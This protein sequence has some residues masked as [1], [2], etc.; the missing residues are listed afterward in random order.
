[1]KAQIFLVIFLIVC[2]VF[3]FSCEK[4][5]QNINTDT[6][7][8]KPPIKEE[9]KIEDTKIDNSM[10]GILSRLPD[11]SIFIVRGVNNGYLGTFTPHEEG[12]ASASFESSGYE[13]NLDSVNVKELIMTVTFSLTSIGNEVE[14]GDGKTRQYSF[15]ILSSELL[16]ALENSQESLIIEIIAE[17]ID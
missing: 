12:I 3:T 1:M 10:K 8:Q 5:G 15:E 7:E 9:Q 13:I 11:V 16:N 2:F 14:S 6:I 17:S 4:N